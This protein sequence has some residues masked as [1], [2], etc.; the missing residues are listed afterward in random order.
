M[1]PCPVRF[2]G[3]LLVQGRDGEGCS[4]CGLG[5]V[6][7][8]WLGFLEGTATACLDCKAVGPL[9]FDC[10]EN[11]LFLTSGI[12]SSGEA[13]LLTRDPA[14]TTVVD[15]RDKAR[16]GGDVSAVVEFDEW[17]TV[18][19]AFDMEGWEGDEVGFVVCIY[20]EKGM[21]NLFY[22]NCSGEGGFLSIV[23]L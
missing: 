3:V 15:L 7:L 17:F 5:T 12:Q 21:A 6:A 18:N 19:E 11:I 16:G 23:A 14:F 8:D 4:F 2:K 9:S 10:V 13:V 1:L 22:V 20:S